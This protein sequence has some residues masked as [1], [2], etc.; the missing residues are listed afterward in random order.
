[1]NRRIV[2]IPLVLATAAACGGSTAHH[3][4]SHASSPPASSAPAAL[5]KPDID[6]AV[7]AGDAPQNPYVAFGSFF[8]SASKATEHRADLEIIRWWSELMTVPCVAIGGITLDTVADVARAG[9]AGD[10]R[11]RADVRRARARCR[12]RR[13]SRL[14]GREERVGRAARIALMR[15]AGRQVSA[16]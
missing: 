6:V 10:A 7:V 2:V 8:P 4:G 15:A 3:S 13:G 9:A 14:P 11:L 16:A 5:T 1:M 12:L